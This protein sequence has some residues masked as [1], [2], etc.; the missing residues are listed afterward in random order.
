MILYGIANCDTVR[1][2]R[3]LLEQAG[4]S[5]LFH[6]FRKE[7]LTAEMIQDWLTHTDYSKL[8]NKR[9]TTWKGF[10]ELEQQAVESQDLQ[11]VCQ[12]PTLIKRPLLDTGSGLLIGFN[13][14]EYQQL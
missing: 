14:S 4:H 2:A 7:G 13:A 9:S 12:H 3:K 10:N 5:F 11:L 6:D 1:K 8:I